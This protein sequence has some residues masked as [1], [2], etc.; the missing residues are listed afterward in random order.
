M[1]LGFS[2]LNL[3][4]N[5]MMYVFIF[6]AIFLFYRRGNRRATGSPKSHN[7]QLLDWIQTEEV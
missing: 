4:N 6:V 2:S 5:L 7:K 1:L 3:Y